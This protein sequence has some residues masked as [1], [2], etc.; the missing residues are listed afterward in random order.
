MS[1]EQLGLYAGVVH[2]FNNQADDDEERR[3]HHLGVLQYLRLVCADPRQY[4]IETFVPEEPLLYRRKAPKMDWLLRTLQGIRTKGEKALIFAEHR[5]VQRLLQH[6]IR[7]EFGVVPQIVNG[8]TSVAA[9]AQRSRQRVIKEFQRA[10]GFGVIILSPLAVGFGINIQAANHVIH[11]LRHWNPAKEDQATDRAY[12]IGQSRDVYVYCPLSVARDFKTFD[13][14]LDELLARKRALA[15]DMLKGTGA[16]SAAEFDLAD[17]VPHAPH[18]M[19]N[20]PVTTELL[21]R[22]SP[23]YFEALAAA[24]WQKQGYR[25]SLTQHSD[26]G[27][28]VVGI[29][30]N[31]GVLIQCKSSSSSDRVLGWEAV[32]DVTGGTAIY[33]EQYPLVRFARIGVTNQRFNRRAHERARANGVRLIEQQDLAG[34]LAQFPIGRL[35]VLAKLSEPRI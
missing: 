11:F 9:K 12:R 29:R 10:P 8:D 17:I 25:C 18:R 35:D 14:K 19:R 27:V 32:R 23:S 6:Y 4:G 31:E 33:G 16:V 34:L 13:V 21:A 20:G 22:C 5:D 30:G 2:L 1:N 7:V 28:D 24:L 15:G 26:A 3:L